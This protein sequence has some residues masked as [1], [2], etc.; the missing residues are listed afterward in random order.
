MAHGEGW[1]MKRIFVFLLGALPLIAQ[2][3]WAETNPESVRELVRQWFRL[4]DSRVNTPELLPMI[5]PEGFQFNFP[6]G[7]LHSNEDFN[8]WWHGFLRRFRH[9]SHNP[10]RIDVDANDKGF[11]VRLDVDFDTDLGTSSS[12]QRWQVR[13]NQGS[14]VISSMKVVRW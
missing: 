3:L 13:D 14:P 2:P 4:Q 8:I 6:E 10:Y 12:F 5:D 11:E 9:F 7:E 1:N